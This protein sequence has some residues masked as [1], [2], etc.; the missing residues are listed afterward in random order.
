MNKRV[1]PYCN[2]EFDCSGK[3]FSN[4]VRWCLENPNK[5][6][7]SGEEYRQKM[8]IINEERNNKK[9]GLIKDF[10]VVCATCGQTFLVQEREKQFPK[11]EKYFCSRSCANKR[12]RPPE[13]KN[14]IA[15]SLKKFNGSDGIERK[16]IICENIIK[17][18]S[19]KRKTCSKECHDILIKQNSEK[20]M[21]KILENVAGTKEEY[22]LKL[23]HYRNCCSFK[24]GI[25]SF[26]DEFDFELVKKHGW[27]SPSNKG[28]NLG[29]VSRDH[30][31]SVKDGFE[32]NVPPEILSHP[33]NCRLIIHNEN[34]SKHRNSCITLDELKERIA[35]WDNKYGI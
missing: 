25:K 31:Y 9:L 10:T 22:T 7:L 29:G 34:V 26:P 17:C 4:H 35:L 8:R 14:K 33:A 12:K 13:V 6:I 2:K 18:N 5:K 11:K 24:F 20:K 28:N 3:I 16:C 19:S 23:R 21:Q 1:C 30:M 32:N 27:Y 15:K